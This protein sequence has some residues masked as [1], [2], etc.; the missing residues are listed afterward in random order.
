MQQAWA[1][2]LERLLLVA[3][4]VAL[5]YLAV[6]YAPDAL[7]VAESMYERVEAHGIRGLWISEEEHEA[8][9][10]PKSRFEEYGF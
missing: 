5:L 6:R 2:R 8:N 10:E 9:R 3:S 4:S 1:L 7:A